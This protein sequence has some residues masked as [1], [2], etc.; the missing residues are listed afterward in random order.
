MASSPA[1]RESA[2]VG[3]RR[4]ERMRATEGSAGMG[5]R[6]REQA[7]R[8]HEPQGQDRGED[9]DPSERLKVQPTSEQASHPTQAREDTQPSLSDSSS[10]EREPAT[11]HLSGWGAA[12][13]DAAR[14]SSIG[15]RAADT[16]DRPKG[17]GVETGVPVVSLAEGPARSRVTA[18]ARQR[19][20]LR[21]RRTAVPSA[22]RRVTPSEAPPIGREQARERGLAEG[23]DGAW[24]ESPVSRP[25]SRPSV[26]EDADPSRRRRRQ[27]HASQ[28]CQ[29]RREPL[30]NEGDSANDPVS[31][32]GRI[33]PGYR[34]IR[35]CAYALATAGLH[36]Q[37]RDAYRQA[38]AGL[39]VPKPVVQV[40]RTPYMIGI[41]G[42]TKNPSPKGSRVVQHG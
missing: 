26:Q 35:L 39:S 2:A 27:Q 5:Q 23:P 18:R 38:V 1:G 10:T 41:A 3:M 24:R 33:S 4:R 17:V 19:Q 6:R 16:G 42:H 36:Q 22:N 11:S 40:R 15:R 21:D 29:R 32:T 12:P 8:R 14:E 30:G 9:M 13:L 28:A 37:L 7:Q 31:Q 25:V 20:A 34:R